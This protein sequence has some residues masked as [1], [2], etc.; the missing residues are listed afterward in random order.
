M[1]DITELAQQELAQLRAELSNQELAA[2]IEQN[3][4]N[5]GWYMHRAYMLGSGCSA[6]EALVHPP[7]DHSRPMLHVIIGSKDA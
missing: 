6:D 2:R 1:T 5:A 4:N 3:P 7:R